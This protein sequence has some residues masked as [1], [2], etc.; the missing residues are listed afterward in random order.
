MTD[1][2]DIRC[3]TQKKKLGLWY[4]I[5]SGLLPFAYMN[6]LQRNS[7]MARDHSGVDTSPVV[8]VSATSYSWRS[9]SIHCAWF[10]ITTERLGHSVRRLI[11]NSTWTAVAFSVSTTRTDVHALIELE[12]TTSPVPSHNLVFI[13][14]LHTTWTIPDYLI[15]MLFESPITTTRLVSHHCAW[16]FLYLLFLLPIANNFQG[17][18]QHL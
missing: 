16:S 6:V 4:Y 9:A 10:D 1:W 7:L 3:W 11:S 18:W 13:T 17:P 8:G 14:V 2:L 12:L 5:R 15:A